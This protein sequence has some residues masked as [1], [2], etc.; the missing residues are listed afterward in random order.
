MII[1][2]WALV[3]SGCNNDIKQASSNNQIA[4]QFTKREPTHSTLTCWRWVTIYTYSS[5][6]NNSNN[7][8]NPNSSSTTSHGQCEDASD[9]IAA[10]AVV[11][12][13]VCA[14]CV[15]ISSLCHSHKRHSFVECKSNERETSEQNRMSA[16]SSIVEIQ[17]WRRNE[18]VFR[19]HTIYTLII[20]IIL[21]VISNILII[22][23]IIEK[24]FLQ[25]QPRSSQAQLELQAVNEYQMMIV[26]KEEEENCF[27]TSTSSRREEN[28]ELSWGNQHH[29]KC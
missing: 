14:F 3:S 27:T 25:Q 28:Q 17:K 18:K 20:I 24:Q 9:T 13:V 2:W 4:E 15:I 21:I 23:K 22:N 29:H 1:E 6:N 16:N 19:R 11:V 5:I 7:N 12:V 26:I 10:A 8:N